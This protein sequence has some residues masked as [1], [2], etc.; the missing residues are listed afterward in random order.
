M[1]STHPG[2]H[3]AE[4]PIG[5]RGE[6]ILRNHPGDV[7]SRAI[8]GEVARVR[9]EDGNDLSERFDIE[10]A[11]GRLTIRPRDRIVLDLGFGRRQRGARRL[12]VEVPHDASV[13]VDTASGRIEAT[14]LRGEQ[15]YRTASGAVDLNA[16]SGVIS[17]DAV[18]GSVNLVAVGPVELSG[19]SVSG[20]VRVDGGTLRS[21][22]FGTTSGDVRLGAPL[23]GPGPYSLQTVSG[24]VEVVAGPDGLRVDARTVTGDIRSDV[25]HVSGS[26]RDN[27]SLTVGGAGQILSFKSI[28]GDLRVADPARGS[29][30]VASHA[31]PEPP[32]PPLPAEPP[33]APAIDVAS[34]TAPPTDPRLEVLR[35]L[36]AG[37][38]DI[39][40]ATR[41]LAELEDGLE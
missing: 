8:D 40:T 27:R 18:S 21:V 11:P 7:D 23:V 39:E 19:R 30:A 5:E 38:I 22:A 16:V 15:R 29:G 26:R 9:D 14:G 31:S 1:T 2:A 24:D 20:D 13:S 25:G 32:A 37:T 28:S 10:A 3:T 4:H 6:V 12:A 34:D 33:A 36:E 35:E 41:R 17:V